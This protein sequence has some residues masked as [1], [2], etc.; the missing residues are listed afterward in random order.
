MRESGRGEHFYPVLMIYQRAFYFCSHLTNPKLYICGDRLGVQFQRL[1]GYGSCR[2][3]F[4]CP[5]LRHNWRYKRFSVLDNNV[6]AVAQQN[7][8]NRVVDRFC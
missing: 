7:A 3:D 5:T 2:A 1:G 8:S 4:F 6:V